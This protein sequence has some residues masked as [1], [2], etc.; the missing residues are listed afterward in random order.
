[1]KRIYCSIDLK[2]FY[3][4]V[5]CLLR[6]A[7]PLDTLLVV[8]DEAR[9][10]KTICLAVTPS[11][12]A[13]GVSGRPRL[14]E[15][16]EV[17]KKANASRVKPLK[18][19]SHCASALRANPHL[20]IDCII[21]KPRMNTYI[22]FSSKVYEIYLKYIAPKDIHLYS[23]DE[24]FMDITSYLGSLSPL[25][26]VSNIL[27][28]IYNNLGLTATAGV[29]SNLYLAKVA[30]DILSK[31]I[32]PSKDTLAIS[33]LDEKLFQSKLWDHQPLQDFWRVGRGYAK[34]LEALGLRSMREVAMYSLSNEEHLYKIFGINAEL[35]I[36]HSWGF[37]SCTMQDIKS[38]TSKSKSKGMG[39]VFCKGYNKQECAM[40]LKEMIDHLSLS[41][42]SDN[43]K[44]NHITLSLIYEPLKNPHSFKGEVSKDSYGRFLPK[45]SNGSISIG[46]YTNS[47]QI[48]SQKTLEL[49]ERIYREDTLVRKVSISFSISKN[50]TQTSQ[51]VN[52]FNLEE[53][54]EEEQKIQKEE[55]MQRARLAITQKY[56]KEALLKASSLEKNSLTHSLI[57]NNGGHNG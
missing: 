2:S 44:S 49:Y 39:K 57:S 14:F 9:S 55:R 26:F 35:L 47:L 6:G 1:M 11:L 23:I 27:K 19:K 8:A 56:G 48:L 7:D 32:T 51:E 25:E 20:E 13:L 34:R 18:G 3:A 53:I 52:L 12:K 43:F 22:S 54:K 5:E 15:V 40:A 31:R 28:D 50:P 46:Y 21:A 4:S 42:L 10:K 30:M 24:V 33:Y 36:D 16:R 45:P 29:G 37:E 38:Y 41:L 17:L